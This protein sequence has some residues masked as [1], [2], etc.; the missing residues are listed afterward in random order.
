[1]E[2]EKQKI[3]DSG[4]VP[5]GWLP[6]DTDMLIQAVRADLEKSKS[7]QTGMNYLFGGAILAGAWHDFASD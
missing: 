2:I 6:D 3:F 1:M 4:K 5:A 7:R